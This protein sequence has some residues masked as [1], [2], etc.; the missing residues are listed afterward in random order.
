MK[1]ILEGLNDE[2][3]EAVAH[4]SGPLMIIAGAGTGK[5]TVMTRRIAWLI[6]QGLAKPDEILAL[7][8]TEKAATE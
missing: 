6:D 1:D 5:T 7:T 8:F 3:R 2:Q 4:T